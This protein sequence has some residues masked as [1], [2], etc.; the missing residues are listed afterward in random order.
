MSADLRKYK[1]LYTYKAFYKVPYLF[2]PWGSEE[3]AL[4]WGYFLDKNKGTSL[5]DDF[6]ER[7]NKKL[8]VGSG[9]SLLGSGRQALRLLLEGT[10]FSHGSEII[11][12]VLCCNAVPKTIKECS[13][14]P[15]FADVGE[16][17]CLGVS[18]IKKMLS[19][20]TKA[21]MLI[22][23]GGAAAAEYKEIVEFCNT[24]ELF[25]IDN[26]AQGW[27]NEVDGIWLGG[28]GNAGIISFG[29]GK[30]TF[31]IGGGMLIAD[32][33]AIKKIDE[34]KAYNKAELLG[35]YLEY[36]RRS[37]TV[38][39][40]MCLNKL[41]N[42]TGGSEIKGI[43]CF[44]RALQY[45]LFKNLDALIKRRKEISMGLMSIL[46]KPPVS[47]P[48]KGNK[49]AWTKLIV[50]MPERLKK[51]FQR[52]LY[53]MRIETE[54]YYS[55]HYLNSYWR[56]AGRFSGAGYPSADKLYKEAFILPNSPRLSVAQL[57]YLYY[58]VG[59]FKVEYL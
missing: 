49:H 58:A 36:L 33:R 50:R 26:A 55:P 7:I 48:Q 59:R 2:P 53:L 54:D 28:R 22:H 10:A 46:D 40:F 24:N 9:V 13:F 42:K 14:I 51:S 17:L 52:Y 43:S 37:Y 56:E 38:P 25:L 15:V 44:D 34:G 8:R 5:T 57:K 21:V 31:G 23:A 47:F 3:D 11:V 12:P 27:G 4:F 1:L 16:D 29:L 41:I 30:S 32:A 39:F 6:E 35:F 19:P 45:L 18:D 20:K